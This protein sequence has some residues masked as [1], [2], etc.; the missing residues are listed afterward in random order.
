MANVPITALRV[1]GMRGQGYT[2][3]A[4]LIPCQSRLYVLPELDCLNKTVEDGLTQLA[5]FLSLKY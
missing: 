5:L 3:T 2:S 1:G 4:V